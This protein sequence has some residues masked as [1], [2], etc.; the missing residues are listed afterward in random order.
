MKYLLIFIYHL[1]VISIASAQDLLPHSAGEIIKH[2][3]YTLSY[4]EQHE[5]AFWV[6]YKLTKDHIYGSTA[7]SD[8]FRPDPK[9]STTSAQLSDYR[10]SGYDRGHLCPAGDMKISPIAMSESFLMSNISPQNRS[11]NGGIWNT[12][13][14]KVRSIA[15]KYNKID[16]VTGP[17]FKDCMGTIGVN[18]I[19]IPGYYYKIIY[20]PIE[21][22]IMIGFLIPNKAE[23]NNIQN[24]ILPVDSIESLTNIDFFPQLSLQLQ[25]D[26][27][28]SVPKEI[29]N[30]INTS[31]NQ[32]YLADIP[33]QSQS[34]ETNQ[35]LGIA[36]STG[37]R[38]KTKTTNPNGYCNDHQF[39]AH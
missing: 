21:K 25:A 31:H 24:Y 37:Q 29:G 33:N 13:E 20:I 30:L 10:D 18:K 8:E 19:T 27:E 16:V 39:Q 3:Y 5:Q 15:K 4:S 28:S 17:V 12:L 9:V 35:C 26:L 34:G 36:K 1:Q 38:C 23:K 2:T 11:F 6:Y 22:P 32:S 14:E 7:R